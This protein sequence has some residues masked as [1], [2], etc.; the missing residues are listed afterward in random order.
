MSASI[1]TTYAGKEAAG[2]ISESLFQGKT[3]AGNYCTILANV[4]NKIAVQRVDITGSLVQTYA[5]DFN[6]VGTVSIDERIL[7]P[8]R[9]MTSFEECITTYEAHWMAEH[10]KPGAN[11]SEPTPEFKKYIID[12]MAKK[13]SQAI[14]FNLWRGNMTGATAAISGYTS[15]TGLLRTI[16]QASPVRVNGATI[17]SSNVY[18]EIGKVYN[19]IP[20]QILGQSIKIFVSY[21]TA[22]AYKF[23]LS[24][25]PLQNQFVGDKPLD[26]LGIELV[27]VPGMPDNFMVAANPANLFVGTDLLSDANEI[28]VVDMRDTLLSDN[29]RY[30]AN[31]SFGTQIGYGSE[32]VLY[33]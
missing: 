7:D 21:A 10:M 19:A 6:S 12:L 13:I 31:Y 29:F 30:R 17:T 20:S 4:K 1:T 15:F 23:A 5:C 24:G 33:K 2:Y 14:E 11:N 3:L 32:I 25:S 9:L 16:D 26:F 27:V 18:S 28:R 22:S 8:T